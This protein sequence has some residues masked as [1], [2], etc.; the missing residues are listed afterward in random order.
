MPSPFPGMDPYL[1]GYLW[2]DVH[3][4][5]ASK[6]RQMLVPLLR[7]R[8]T[9][10]LEVYLAQDSM[11]EGEVGILYPDVE[12][13]QNRQSTSTQLP[14]QE[15]VVT[16]P[17]ALTLPLMLPIQV[18]IPTVEIRDTAQNRLVACVEIL[19]PVN[20]REPGLGEYRRKR[21][22]L[23]EADVH[24]IELDLLRRGTRL[25]NHPRLPAV[26]YLVTLTRSRSGRVQVWPIAFQ[27]ALPT[28]PIPLREPDPDVAL[29]LGAVLQTIYDEAAYELSIDYA[30]APPPPVLSATDTSWLE[31]QLAAV[32]GQ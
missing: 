31:E 32:R 10:R 11:P 6:I 9:A 12:V 23:Y 30:Q 13:L 16:T 3:N 2:P 21:Q 22:R 15:A 17:A 27:D 24:L 28:I 4:S 8:Y 1:E 5:I 26:A 29:D 19:S 25:F 7:P 20:K 18:R 14:R